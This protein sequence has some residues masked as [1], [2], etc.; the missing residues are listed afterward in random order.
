MID[1]KNALVP[2]GVFVAGEQGFE[3]QILRPE[4]NVMPF[5]HS[6]IL[7][8]ANPKSA[9]PPIDKPPIIQ[10]AVLYHATLERASRVI[11]GQSGGNYPPHQA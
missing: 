9:V 4:R 3:P 8:P 6:P 5:H 1:A 10:R 2:E 7:L 11:C